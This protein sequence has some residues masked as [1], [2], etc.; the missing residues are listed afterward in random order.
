MIDILSDTYINTKGRPVLVEFDTAS[1]KQSIILKP[2]ALFNA[3][4]YGASN[5]SVDGKP[6]RR[7]C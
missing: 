1:G 6:L 4:F 7:G 3:S 5:I 2:N